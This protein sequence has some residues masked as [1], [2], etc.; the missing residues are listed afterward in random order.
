MHAYLPGGDRFFVV[1]LADVLWA[2]WKCRNRVTFE[3]YK[4]RFP[5]EIVFSA[6]TNLLSWAGL[7]KGVDA[8]RLRD[9]AQKLIMNA[10]VDVPGVCTL[11]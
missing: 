2:T 8:E 9:G 6:C 3:A 1:G 11:F 4:L 7:Q 5:F 10:H